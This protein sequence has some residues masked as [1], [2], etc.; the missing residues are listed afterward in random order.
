MTGGFEIL[1]CVEKEPIF[2][3]TIRENIKNGY[4]GN[5]PIVYETDI[6]KLNPK[7][8]LDDIGIKPGEIDVLIGGPPCQSFSTAGKRG[9]VKDL[10]GTLIWDYVRFVKEIQPKFFLLE[11]VR[12]LMSAALSHRPIK[13]RPENGGKELS[14]EETPGSVVELLVND[15]S[16]MNDIFYHV[17][18]FEVNAVNYGAP[19]IRE[20]VLFIGNRFNKEIDFPTPTHFSESEI[21][22]NCLFAAYEKWKTLGDAI[23]GIEDDKPIIL[24]FSP[25]KKKY[26]SLIPPGGNWR[27]LP[28]KLQKESLGNAYYAKGGKSGW[29]RRLTYDLPCPTLVTMPNHASTSLCH[30]QE[31]RALSIKEYCMIQEFPKSWIICGNPIEQYRQI[32][33]AVPTRLGMVAGNVI[34]EELKKI[35]GQPFINNR[36]IVKPFRRVYLHSHVRTR[37]WY[38]NGDVLLWN[39]NG[40]KPVYK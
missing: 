20:R 23:E 33:N 31:I 12:G 4:F 27:S 25:R 24:D 37:R 9:T 8:L 7:Q 35:D 28:Q 16:F 2:C 6:K 19:Q 21:D 11:N 5:K 22:N 30:P 1:A 15:L 13:T 32:G 26:L 18:C 17:D 3:E 10:R 29:W 14:K 40:K 34:L 38:K 36:Q 39:E